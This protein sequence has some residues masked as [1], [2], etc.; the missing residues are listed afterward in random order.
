MPS[1]TPTPTYSPSYVAPEPT[2][3]A[4][5]TGEVIPAGTALNPSLAA[6]I[7]NHTAARPQV[8]LDRTDI[9]FEE[10]VEGGLTRYVAIWQSDVQ[11]RKS[12]V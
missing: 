2:G 1:A 3:L 9:V 10:L 12:V 7:D 5:L 8:G 6:K 11:D 4:P